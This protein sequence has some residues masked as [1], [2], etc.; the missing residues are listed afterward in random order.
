MSIHTDKLHTGFGILKSFSD[1]LRGFITN[2]DVLVIRILTRLA[3]HIVPPIT[4]EI[5]LVKDG[6]IGTDK[7]VLDTAKDTA[8]AP[9]DVK[10]LALSLHI[11]IVPS[12]HPPSTGEGGVRDG[13]VG[14]VVHVWCSGDCIC[15]FTFSLLKR[16]QKEHADLY[17]AHHDYCKY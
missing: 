9:T 12:H 16:K 11:S 8:A 2:V 17:K 13:G 4:S 1:R 7:A 14:G 6:A 15:K 5:L 10:D 3:V